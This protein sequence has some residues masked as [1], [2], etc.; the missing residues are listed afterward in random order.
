MDQ[1]TK[2]SVKASIEA[3]ADLMGIE[4]LPKPLG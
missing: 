1:R 2:P 4:P 3:A